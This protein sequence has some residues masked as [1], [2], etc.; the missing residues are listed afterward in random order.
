MGEVNAT[1]WAERLMLRFWGG[2]MIL[3]LRRVCLTVEVFTRRHQGK[4]YCNPSGVIGTYAVMT[5][6]LLT[7]FAAG[8]VV[9]PEA[10]L[11]GPAH[12]AIR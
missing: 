8:P 3:L 1:S 2:V 10:L 9:D 12:A 4:D 7:F 11:A 5:L 6:L